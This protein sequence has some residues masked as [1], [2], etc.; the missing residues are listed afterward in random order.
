[1][2]ALLALLLL[3]LLAGCEPSPP[4]QPW[5]D[6]PSESASM[7]ADFV[8]THG[9]EP[10]EP[11][12]AAVSALAWRLH[13]QLAAGTDNA[14]WSPLSIAAALSM[15]AAGAEGQTLAELDAVLDGDGAN[16]DWHR[17]LGA[18]LLGLLEIDT[19]QGSRL[20]LASD[21]WLQTGAV[22][23]QDFLALLEAAYAAAPRRLDFASDPE[24]ARTAI[25]RRVAELTAGLIPELLAPGS[26]E[27]TSRLVLSNALYL[28]AAWRTPF[29]DGGT[30][31]GPFTRLDGRSIE[32][33]MMLTVGDFEYARA[34]NWQLLRL[35]YA[36]GRLEL[37]LLLPDLDVFA[38][39]EAELD[40][41]W[42][43]SALAATQMRR[44]E[45]RMPRF[46]LRQRLPLAQ[47][48]AAIGVRRI[49]TPQAELGRIGP[50]LLVSAFAHQAVL[51]VD[52]HGTEAAAATAAVI[53]IT[54]AP[55]E[56]PLPVRI[57]RPFLVWIRDQASGLILFQARVLDPLAG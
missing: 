44:L 28:K 30:E 18:E 54:S 39:L 5:S 51:I 16:A 12:D 48:L 27:R 45:L 1:M 21:L 56:L 36:D 2:K 26:V 9:S 15:L 53:G 34:A 7:P 24:A 23:G 33:P 20:R 50:E 37:V 25:N 41:D 4:A 38:D 11:S 22:V 55:I 3:T 31:P 42:L 47:L 52:E 46:E 40:A 14:V 13:Q 17:R 29:L 6:P 8:H 43:A 57:D 35:P 49:F 19:A 10:A 32:V